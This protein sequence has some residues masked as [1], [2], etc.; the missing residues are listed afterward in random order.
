MPS[1]SASAYTPGAKFHKSSFVF[2]HILWAQPLGM[3]R[4][5]DWELGVKRHRADVSMSGALACNLHI[6]YWL[7]H[8][9]G[10]AANPRRINCRS[11][12]FMHL[13]GWVV[14][15]QCSYKPKM[16]K[17]GNAV[18]KFQQHNNPVKLHFTTPPMLMIPGSGWSV[19]PWLRVDGFLTD[20][21]PDSWETSCSCSWASCSAGAR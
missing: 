21:P 14:W 5:N 20:V 6:M 15:C 12:Q 17:I 1:I 10:E 11:F 4:S 18:S 19:L 9:Q 7:C 8:C 2:P 3:L 16:P 13:D